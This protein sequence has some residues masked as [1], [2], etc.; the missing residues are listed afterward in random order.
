MKRGPF[1]VNLSLSYAVQVVILVIAWVALYVSTPTFRGEAAVYATLQGFALLGIVALGVSCTMIAGELDLSAAS[2][3][4]LASVLAVRFAGLGLIPTIVIAVLICGVL[5]AVQGALITWFRINSM[6]FTI[7]TLTLFQG[8]AYI[9]SHEGP[10]ILNNFSVSNGLLSRWWI[11]SPSSIV[12]VIV[13]VL[14]GVAL[15]KTRWGREIYAIGG[16]R[17]EAIA[18]GVDLRKPIVRAFALSGLCAGLAGALA[19]IVGGSATPTSFSDLLLT[20]VAAAL[21]GG[22]GLAGGRGTA[23]HT[24]IGVAVISAITAGIAS[25]GD[26][27]YVSDLTIGIV[28][29]VTVGLQALVLAWVARTRVQRAQL[30]TL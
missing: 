19:G 13:F 12:A 23:V 3:A 17:R 30:A 7:G 15:A 2:M 26:Q 27:T 29:I 28:L 25:R 5:G 9:A 24:A 18:A 10:V 4:T 1:L 22:I 11:F 21:V 14:V 6:V 8:V 16:G 20:S